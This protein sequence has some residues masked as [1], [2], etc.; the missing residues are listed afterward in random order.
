MIGAGMKRLRDGRL[1]HL[2]HQSHDPEIWVRI[3]HRTGQI[4]DARPDA[5][6]SLKVIRPETGARFLRR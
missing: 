2:F 4:E 1:A 5:S 3:R 6:Q